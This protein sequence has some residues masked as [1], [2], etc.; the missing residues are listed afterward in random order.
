MFT[1][2][3]KKTKTI[4]HIIKFANPKNRPRQ[5]E[6][7]RALVELF[8]D[9]IIKHNKE[10]TEFYVKFKNEDKIIELIEAWAK[11]DNSP[12]T[13]NEAQQCDCRCHEHE[14]IMH[15]MPCCYDGL[16]FISPNGIVLR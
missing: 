12:L 6:S 14:D 9:E 16:A 11:N 8:T 15:F 4:L 5:K 7:D 3:P 2:K 10:E 1:N 13:I